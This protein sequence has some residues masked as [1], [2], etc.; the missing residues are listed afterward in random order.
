MRLTLTVLRCPP[1]VT[2][3]TR[4]VSGGEF[5]AG[6]G[7]GVDWV[8]PDTEQVVS[9]RHF[10]AVFRAGAWQIIDHGANGTFLNHDTAPIGQGNARTLRNADRLQVGPYEI[11]VHLAEKE[12]TARDAAYSGITAAHSPFDD[13]LGHAFAPAGGNPFDEPWVPAS[14]PGSGAA[15]IPAAFD[16]L[17]PADGSG[18]FGA[19]FQEAPQRDHSSM[20]DDAYRPPAQVGQMP[21]HAGGLIPADDL[22]PAGWETDFLD[23]LAPE[24]PPDA[25]RNAPATRE[26]SPFESSAAVSAEPSITRPAVPPAAA[27]SPFEEEPPP[28]SR[29]AASIGSPGPPPQSQPNRPAPGDDSRLL[30]Q[31]LAGVGLPDAKPGDPGA[32]MGRLGEAFR[33]LVAGLR[34][35]LIAR[36]SIKSEFRIDQTMFR[37]RGNNPLKFSADDDD[38]VSALLGVGRRTGMT[39]AQAIADVLRDIELH[40]LASMAAMQSAVR[41]VLEGLGPDKLRAEADQGGVALLP[42]Q[43]KARAWDAYE[44][45]H[46]KTVQALSDDFDSVFGKAFARAYEE[47]MDDL[48]AGKRQ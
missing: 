31:F 45:R 4:T 48:T 43:R 30:T 35:V 33:S 15:S 10:A 38:A 3:E 18:A 16:P 20:L 25:A 6:R 24:T 17:A 44:V 5:T 11:E 42:V 40:E 28:V 19:A 12:E 47:A 32:T 13:P 23:G 34:S 41:A 39:A 27:V 7:P 8:L 2:P 22:L 21:V 36:A 46:A 29:P 14:D 26:A 9:K 1:A 37:A